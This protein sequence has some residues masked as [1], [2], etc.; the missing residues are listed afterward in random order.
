[1]KQYRPDFHIT[2]KTGWINDPNGFVYFKN[3]FFM[4]AQHN[5]YDCVWGPVH[6]LAFSSSDLIH[7]NEEGVV[8]KPDSSYDL[9]F[10]C[11][12]GSSIVKEDKLYVLYTGVNNGKQTQC[13]A[14]SNDG[15]HFEK[16]KNNPVID[17]TLLPDGYLISDF[18]DPKVFYKFGY[19][20]VIVSAK[21]KDNY[22]SILLFKSKDLFNWEFVNVLKNSDVGEMIE[23]PSIVFDND[24][25]ALIYSIQF[26]KK[27]NLSFQNI[28]SVVYQ[29]GSFDGTNF[30]P[31]G[32]VKEYD[33]GFDV[34]ATYT[35]E[36]QQKN[37]LVY[38]LMMWDN[39]YPTKKEG[40]AG[41][42]SSIREIKI[43]GD[44]LISSFVDEVK[45]LP[46]Y[47]KITLDLDKKITTLNVYS[48]LDLVFNK[49]NNEITISRNNMSDSI[50]CSRGFDVLSRTFKYH[51]S[52]KVTLEFFF[53]NSAVEILIDEG[54]ASFSLLDF[55]YDSNLNSDIIITNGGNKNEAN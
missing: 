12:S 35:L 19:Y 6:W 28:H 11:F 53:D 41:Q 54:K 46:N 20:Y 17:E 3:K 38:W 42:L 39:E 48:N 30:A 33:N 4:Y 22:S 37:L 51:L 21:H 9:E 40:Y 32:E 18:R 49:E 34:Y 10:G 44:S 5:P 7:W 25:C 47:K 24:K 15:L 31:S 36:Y 16:Y 27:E 52:N 1:M 55:S 2:P 43:V 8:L 50:I 13:L 14:V 23:C 26:K 45:K 29:V